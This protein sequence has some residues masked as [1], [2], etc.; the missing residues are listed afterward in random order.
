M[1]VLAGAII[2]LSFF[3]EVLQ[4]IFLL[5][6][7]HFLIYLPMKIYLGKIPLSQIPFDLM[8]EAGWTVGFALLNLLIWR[9]GIRQYMA[10]GD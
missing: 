4:K 5:L 10:M 1:E 6:P 7:F 8:K 2:P 9:R 3:P